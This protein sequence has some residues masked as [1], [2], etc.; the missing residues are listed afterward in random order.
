[1]YYNSAKV[2]PGGCLF[3]QM[4][5]T[6]SVALLHCWTTQG[7]SHDCSF[8][9]ACWKNPHK[10][11]WF[12][13]EWIRACVFD[14]ICFYFL[15]NS[16]Y[17][18]TVSILISFIPECRTAYHIYILYYFAHLVP[19]LKWLSTLENWQMP[20]AA[21]AVHSQQ[22]KV[23]IMESTSVGWVLNLPTTNH[24]NK[25]WCD[26]STTTEI[27]LKVQIEISR[28]CKNKRNMLNCLGIVTRKVIIKSSMDKIN[29]Q[30]LFLFNRQQ[31]GWFE[32]WT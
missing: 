2:K 5:A 8:S 15:M 14:I 4:V 13:V 30:F 21:A 20:F 28:I 29:W 18:Y 26:P 17:V 10:T 32:T 22:W 16:A 25:N 11:T 24:V 1:M 23:E 27:G 6:R 3:P 12:Y 19:S 7:W 31:K 9:T